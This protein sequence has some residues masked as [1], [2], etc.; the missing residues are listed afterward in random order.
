[1]LQTQLCSDRSGPKTTLYVLESLICWPFRPPGSCKP[2][3]DLLCA[4]IE[5]GES[6]LADC[7]SDAIASSENADH[8]SGEL[9]GCEKNI[10]RVLAC[11]VVPCFQS[12]D[13]PIRCSWTIDS[14]LQV[15]GGCLDRLCF[16]TTGYLQ[17]NIRGVS[18][19]T[20]MLIRGYLGSSRMWVGRVWA[21]QWASN[22]QMLLKPSKSTRTNAWTCRSSSRDACRDISGLLMHHHHCGSQCK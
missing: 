8:A 4:D 3:I 20:V 14:S 9:G 10:Q 18:A 11:A 12:W 2:E 6:K 19:V 17:S 22:K 21:T 7:I 16:S 1:M 5:E 13:E 15:V